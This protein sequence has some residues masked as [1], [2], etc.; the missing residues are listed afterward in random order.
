MCKFCHDGICT[1][2][3]PVRKQKG[4]LVEQARQLKLNGLEYAKTLG[5]TIEQYQE[6]Y[7]NWEDAVIGCGEKPELG[8][9]VELKESIDFQSSMGL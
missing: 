1:N 3:C 8:L 9:L 6:Y 5:L 7:N 4:E 2:R